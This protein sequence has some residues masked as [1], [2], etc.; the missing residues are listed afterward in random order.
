MTTIDRPFTGNGTSTSILDRERIIATAGFN[1]WLVPPAA[2]CIHLCIGMAYGFS[3]FHRKFRKLAVRGPS[4]RTKN[5]RKFVCNNARTN[6]K[7][8]LIAGLFCCR[9]GWGEGLEQPDNLPLRVDVNRVGRRN[10]RQTRHGH[11]LSADRH[12]ELGAR[13]KAHLAHRDGMVD[14]SSLKIRIG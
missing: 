13:G 3:V 11:D 12:D 7:G 6:E 8:P 9:L 1:R 14:G 5:F 4:K 2:L 10:L